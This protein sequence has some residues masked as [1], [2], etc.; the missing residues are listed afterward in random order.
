MVRAVEITLQDHE[1][2]IFANFNQILIYFKLYYCH[3]HEYQ[4]KHKIKGHD[5]L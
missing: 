2:G 3:F 1:K 4:I 5:G